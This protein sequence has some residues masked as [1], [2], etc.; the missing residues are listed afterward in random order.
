MENSIIMGDPDGRL[1]RSYL[2]HV[3]ED[4]N[5][6]GLY[7]YNTETFEPFHKLE[8]YFTE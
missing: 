1:D 4:G 3:N 7:F 6:R 8:Y 2:A 5:M